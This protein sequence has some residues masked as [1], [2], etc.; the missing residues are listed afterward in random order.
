M[1][2]F[3]K[4]CLV[5]NEMRYIADAVQ[6]GKISGN[7]YYTQT[8]QQFFESEFGYLK[9]LLTNSCTDA[10]EMAA[11][12][13]D[14]KAGDEIIMSAF[15]HVSTANAF[16]LRGAKVVFV[17]T[18]PDTPN[19]D[20]T[21]ISTLITKNTKAIVVVHYG[22]MA[23]NMQEIL[24]LAIAHNLYIIEDAAAALGGYYGA[25]PLGSIGHL[26][27]ISFHE[28]KNVQCGEGGLLIINDERLIARAEVLWE[29][30]TNRVAFNR[31][32]IPAYDW[33]DIGSS[34]L[35]SEINAA[36]LFAQLEQFTTI[37]TVRK[38]QWDTYY[39]ALEPLAETGKIA[40]PFFHPYARHNHHVFALICQ[41]EDM[42]N[43]LA[44]Q[45]IEAGILA[46]SHY[47]ALH[48]SPYFTGLHDG[49]Q[50]PNAVNFEQRLLRLP[51]YHDL[52][53]EEIAIICDRVKTLV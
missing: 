24:H 40:L 46:V 11:L 35:P 23:V 36:F 37:Q 33:I 47:R 41:N 20:V 25:L 17:D 5:G 15:T 51:L 30:G 31:R 50:L 44:G 10:L 12:L 21:Q 42:R 2:P 8:C 14:V 34:Y 39:G 27:A 13:I 38:Q 45:L 18:A 16:L 3:N 4:P 28:T 43:A 53:L 52:K 9:T 19:I 32:E 22:G 29:K 1:I 48:H 49:R 26:G 7:G 6:R